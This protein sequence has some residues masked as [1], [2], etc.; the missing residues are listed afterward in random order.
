MIKLDEWQKEILKE[1]GNICLRSGRQ[2]GKST[3]IAIKASIYASENRNSSVMIISSTERQAYLLFSKVLGYLV[4]NFP[5]LIKKGKERPTKS[6][7]QLQNGSIIRCL[8]TGLDGIGIRGYTVNLLIADEA[9]FINGDVWAAV[10]PML[11]TT[12]GKIWLLS[13]PYGREGYFYEAFHNPDFK[14]FHISTEDV[15]ELRDEP[16]RTHMRKNFEAEKKRMSK[17]QYAQEYLGEFVDELR[18]YFSDE[19]IKK[20]CVLNR[21]QQIRGKAYMGCDIARMGGD[22]ITYE[23]VDKVHKEL[24]EHRESIAETKKYLTETLNRIVTLTKQWN[25]RKIGIDA[26]SGSLGVALL[27]FLLA[28]SAT[29]EKIVPLTNQKRNIDSDGKRKTSLM[30]EDM[31]ANLLAWME[32]GRLRLL[33]DDEIIESLKSVQYEFDEVKDGKKTTIRIF[34]KYTHITEGLTRAVWLASEDKSLNLWAR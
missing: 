30:K 32:S 19:V 12:G 20:S 13:T 23:V 3:I 15:A 2:V 5:K 31:Y 28:T 4:D 11:S 33:N 6:Q 27:D 21:I 34:G 9:A 22:E 25:I 26:G 24:I 17:L 1:Q 14:A 10:T 18:R 8:P 29:R 16:Q 7:I